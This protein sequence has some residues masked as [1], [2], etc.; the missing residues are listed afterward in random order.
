MSATERRQLLLEVLCLR[1]RDT[2]DNLANEFSVSKETI[3]HDV[4][5]LMCSYPIET[6]RGR[7]GG[8]KVAEGYFLYRNSLSQKQIALLKRVREQLGGDDLDTLDSIL[9]QFSPK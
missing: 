7:Y 5:V 2:Y 4:L 6:V 9:F 1:R 8:V 3:R